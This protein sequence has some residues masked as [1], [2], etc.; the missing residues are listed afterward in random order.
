MN[1]DWLYWYPTTW[2]FWI[3]VGFLIYEALEAIA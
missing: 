2:I 3:A 1:K